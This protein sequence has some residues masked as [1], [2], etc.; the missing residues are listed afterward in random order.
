MTLTYNKEYRMHHEVIQA[1]TDDYPSKILFTVEEMNAASGGGGGGGSYGTG[2]FSGAVTTGGYKIE[3]NSSF[4]SATNYNYNSSYIT[5]ND[6]NLNYI[7]LSHTLPSSLPLEYHVYF[8]SNNSF[9]VNSNFNV[10]I[11][12]SQM[13]TYN[14]FGSPYNNSNFSIQSSSSYRYEVILKSRNTSHSEW[15]AEWREYRY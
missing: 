9:S 15:T 1:S 11:N 5:Y 2:D 8:R 4:S 7:N 14:N 3:I 6:Y 13:T 10:Q 12:G